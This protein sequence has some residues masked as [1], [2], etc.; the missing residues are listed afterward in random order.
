MVSVETT[1]VSVSR[2]Q[3]LHTSSYLPSIA[4]AAST[5]GHFKNMSVNLGPVA[6]VLD[7]V[8]S[9]PALDGLG[10]NPRCLIQDISQHASSTGT[11]DLNV[12]NLVTRNGDSSTFQDDMQGKFTATD[13]AIGV[14]S[15]GHYVVGGVP[16]SDLYTSPGDPYFFLHRRWLFPT[17]HLIKTSSWS[18]ELQANNR[19]PNRP[20]MVH[21]AEPG[22]RHQTVHDRRQSHFLE[23]PTE[24]QRY[25]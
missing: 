22:S 14:H 18:A 23:C 13:A 19:R 9:K 3:R 4:E 21:L 2:V 8:A 15:A 20:H 12:T 24:Y 6:A 16:G 7:Y 25:S 5:Q 1:V 17:S 11:T 10:H